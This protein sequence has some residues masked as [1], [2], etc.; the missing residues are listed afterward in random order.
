MENI[1]FVLTGADAVVENGGIINKIGSYTV[2]I[3][4][5]SH[6]R[7]FYVLAE[8]FKFARLFPLNQK[9]I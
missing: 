6:G 4:A 2:A 1:D 7:P 8:S 5:K 3:A 9:D